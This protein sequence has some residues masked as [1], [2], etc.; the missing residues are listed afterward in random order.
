MNLI[1][2]IDPGK[3]GGLAVLDGMKV[4]TL[5]NTPTSKE[6][7]RGYDIE[8]MVALLSNYEPHKVTV[9]MEKVGGAPIGGN[10][11]G[12]QGMFSF[13]L[14]VGVWMGIIETLGFNLVLVTPQ[15]WKK[16]M[17]RKTGYDKKAS[18]IM[19]KE[20]FPNA[21]LKPGRKRVDDHNL[22]EAL[23]IA[24]YGRLQLAGD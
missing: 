9:F 20:L 24:F 3:S 14:G 22:A 23:L 19:A 10:R 7:I 21:D 18:V 2:G 13:G 1:I 5:V 17:F 8:Q 16:V 15:A 11:K 12:A 6:G 4:S